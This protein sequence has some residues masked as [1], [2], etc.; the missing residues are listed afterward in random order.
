M[1]CVQ[2]PSR[3][4]FGLLSFPSGP[5]SLPVRQFGGVGLMVQS[6][7]VCLRA[8]PAATWSAEGTLAERALSYAHRLAAALPPDTVRPQHLVVVQSA[9]EHAGLGTGTQLGL[10]VA[11]AVMAASGFG[12]LSAVELAQRIERGV[13][14]AL[15]IHGFAQGGFLVDGGKSSS[16]TVA[17]LVARLEFPDP[18]RVLLLLQPRE[19]G[20]HGAGEREAFQR[21]SEQGIPLATT[22]ALCR[23]VL[24]G[25]LPALVERDLNS[26][27]EALYEFNRRVGEAFAP[28]QGGAYAM[29]RIAER[30]SFLRRHGVRGAGQSSWGPTVFAIVPDDEYGADLAGRVR[31]AF[32]LG[33]AEVLVTAAC[34]RGATL[35][36]D[37]A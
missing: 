9:P 33:A 5:Q 11:R 10:A 32:A 3:L 31:E 15:G 35:A 27:G 37:S 7:G 24:L 36:T 12:Q 23:L 6:P 30:I 16:T 4:H 22:D 14:S 21:L 34:N 18:W 25:L 28:V 29:P 20:R 26:F 1:I 19:I 13:R 17:P 8:Q 2:A